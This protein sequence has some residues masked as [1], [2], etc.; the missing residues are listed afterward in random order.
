MGPGGKIDREFL[1]GYELPR[2]AAGEPPRGPTETMIADFWVEALDLPGI[3]RD[4]DFFDAGGDSL[5]GAIVAAEIHA[6]FGIEISLAALAAHPT[7]SA[8]A[9]HVDA[10][11]K[12][13]ARRLPPIVSVSRTEP[14]PLSPYQERVWRALERRPG[15]AVIARSYD[16]SGP[17]DVKVMEECFRYLVDRH[18]ILRTTFAVVDGQPAQIVHP[19]AP[20][21]F[22][23]VDVSGEENP[24]A[25]AELIYRTEAAKLIDPAVLPVMRLLLVRI[26][27][28][29]H[30]LMRAGHALGQDASSFTI[31][32]NEFAALYDAGVGGMAPPIPK[33][34]PLQYADY[35]VWH[36]EF[37]RPD[38]VAYQQMLDW[39]KQIFAKRLRTTRL[40]RHKASQASDA[41]PSQATLRWRLEN[42]FGEQLDTTARRAGAT[43]FVIRLACFV[44]LL[45]DMTGRST[46]V[47]GTSFTYR[48]RSDTRNIA[49][50]FTNLAPLVFSYRSDLVLSDWVEMVRDRLFE[51][52][53]HAELP[54]EALYG[55]L[56]AAGLRPPSI[57]VVFTMASDWPEQRISGIVMK[58]RP[59]PL[60][61]MPWGC[62]VYIDQKKPANC[63]VDFDANLY[64][65]DDMQ[66]MTARY[67][68]LLEAAAEHPNLPI[69]KLVALTSDSRL[70]QIATRIKIALARRN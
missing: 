5:T 57:Q 60:A 14:I 13:S 19:S 20:L 23:F 36:R 48:Q 26:G 24:E 41:D 52:E 1:R 31:I 40:P 12:S 37:M 46:V 29:K 9:A 47:L 30:W 58:R 54:L 59:P 42:G 16:I 68:R 43:H 69:G 50:L 33:D 66:A 34:M 2:G 64:R 28:E 22:S 27:E 44:A 38:G 18:E 8:L 53:R 11:R 45:A 55:E 49:G 6:A 3:G 61:E 25:A 21:G 62:Q 32:M 35:A 39:W 15:Y 67:V 56:R 17:V 65:P 63:R 51:T 10:E 7:V 4:G 70:R